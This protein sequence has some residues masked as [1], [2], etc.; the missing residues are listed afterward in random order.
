[1]FEAERKVKIS[2]LLFNNKNVR[3]IG[4]LQTLLSFQTVFRREFHETNVFH[5]ISKS[6][7]SFRNW[8]SAG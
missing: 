7:E 6:S 2:F 3:N 1:M 8:F 5:L 4:K